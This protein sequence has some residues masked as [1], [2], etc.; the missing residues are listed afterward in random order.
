V[1]SSTALLIALAALAATPAAPRAEPIKL[2]AGMS[3]EL[4]LQHHVNSAYTPTGAPIYFRVLKDVVVDDH[5]LIRAGTLAAGRM[6]QASKRGMVGRSGFMLASIRTV[7]AVDGTAVAVDCDVAKQGRSRAGATV[8][9][10]LFW[11]VPGLITKGVNPYLERGEHFRAAVVADTLIDADAA[12]E[13]DPLPEP[14]TLFT[15][16]QYTFDGT[17]STDLTFDIERDANLETV[18]FSVQVP[19]GLE[20]AKA[21]LQGLRLVAV[22]GVPVPEPI[23]ATAATDR[24]VTFDG[25]S[26]I[27]YCRDGITELRFRA[28]TPN[29]DAIDAVSRIHIKIRKKG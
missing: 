1:R 24:S 2:P 19:K 26:I 11:G 7:P 3:V 20:D 22:D 13:Q 23:T 16:S 4:E 9:W 17:R 25:W 5:V 27:R 21:V 6:E 18:T 15:I 10:T 14:R 12:S 28:N 29:G 8:A